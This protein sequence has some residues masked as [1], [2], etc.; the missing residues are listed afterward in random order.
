MVMSHVSTFPKVR[1]MFHPAWFETEC[2]ILNVCVKRGCSMSQKTVGLI[3]ALN[4]S[5]V[6]SRMFFQKIMIMGL[7]VRIFWAS[8]RGSSLN[9]GERRIK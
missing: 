5:G 7:L 4:L 8:S 6:A 1:N 3:T 2:S 9:L